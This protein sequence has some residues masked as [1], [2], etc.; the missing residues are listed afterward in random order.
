MDVFQNNTAQMLT[1]MR[2]DVALKNNIWLRRSQ[3]SE[4]IKKCLSEKHI[5]FFYGFYNVALSATRV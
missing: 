5:E 1:S 2:R 4:F 3:R